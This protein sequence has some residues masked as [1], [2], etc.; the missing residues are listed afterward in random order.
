MRSNTK[1]RYGLRTM[2]QIGID[3]EAGILQKGI[4]EKQNISYKYL[5]HIIAPLKASGL[6]RKDPHKKAYV[7]AKPAKDILAYDI[8]KAFEHE[9]QVVP[10]I[11]NELSECEKIGSCAAEEFWQGLNNVIKDYFEGKTLQDLVDKQKNHNS[12]E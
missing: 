2:I 1:V 10:C 12:K 7:L 8:Y 6:I 9:L 5:D 4:S 3:N 11:N